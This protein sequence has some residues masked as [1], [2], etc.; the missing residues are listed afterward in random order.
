MW[1]MNSTTVASSFY[2]SNVPVPWTISSVG[3]FN[4]DGKADIFWSDTVTGER[5]MWL[6]NGGTLLEGDYLGSG[7]LNQGGA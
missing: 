3:D 4:G 5:A 6:M 1:L 7:L 2:L